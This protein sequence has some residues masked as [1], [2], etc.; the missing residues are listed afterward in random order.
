M[1][2]LS[3]LILLITVIFSLAAGSPSDKTISSDT[4]LKVK[5]LGEKIIPGKLSKFGYIKKTLDSLPEINASYFLG[6]NSDYLYVYIEAIGD[7]IVTRDRGYQNGDGFHLTIG[8]A[9]NDGSETDE[10]FVLGFSAKEGWSRKMSWYYNVDLKMGSLGDDVRFESFKREGKICFE[11]LIPWNIIKPYH[12]W[13]GGKIGFNLCFVKA[14]NDY[15]KLYSFIVKDDR[16]QSEQSKRK[17]INLNFEAPDQVGKSYSIPLR[18][19]YRRG[20]EMKIEIA[21][22]AEKA[23]K[24]P[25]TVKIENTEKTVIA[26]K[27]I[28]L[29]V[30]KGQYNTLLSYGKIGLNPGNYYIKIYESKKEIGEHKITIIEEFNFNYL[31]KVIS[32]TR[33]NISK[34]TLATILFR[35]DETERELAKLKSYESCENLNNSILEIKRN[36]SLLQTGIDPFSKKTG[37]YRRAYISKNDSTLMPYYIY[38]PQDYDK[39][40]S[41]PLLVYL[42]GSGQDDRVLERAEFI[43]EGYIVVAPNGRGVSNCFYTKESQ[44][45][46]SEAIDDVER[47][48]NIDRNR[49]VLSGFSMGGYGVFRTFFENPGRYSAIAIISGHPDLARKMVDKKGINFLDEKYKQLFNN[50]SVFIYHSKDDLNC[51]YILMRQF[52]E[53]IRKSNSNVRFVEDENRGH[54]NMST[55]AKKE[56]YK[57]LKK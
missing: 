45:D 55:E 12:P 21:G 34:G 19:N 40:H 50:V 49:V 46:I 1:N 35:I 3:R 24:T 16:M 18:N 48:F 9:K 30:K 56:Y 11:A 43:K 28:S 32:M 33:S 36:T 26:T 41:Y 10:F 5:F 7:S 57:W 51:P 39:N 13:I 17:Y 52:A 20:D 2:L 38:V 8:K 27:H 42:H 31:R 4:G 53:N 29:K 54:G 15:D 37:T 14:M 47:E 25:F 22:Y 44:E 6:Y 23:R